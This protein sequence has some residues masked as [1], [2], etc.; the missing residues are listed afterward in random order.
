MWLRVVVGVVLCL[1][2]VVWIGQGVGLMTHVGVGPGVDNAFPTEGNAVF[3][4]PSD[5]LRHRLVGCTGHLAAD[6]VLI[7]VLDDVI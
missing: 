3:H 5:S 6:A 1:V 7:E 2:G 4:I